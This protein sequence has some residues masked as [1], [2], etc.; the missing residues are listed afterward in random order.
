MGGFQACFILHKKSNTA[1][2]T[3]N[4]SLRKSSV[5]DNWSYI[6]CHCSFRS[7]FLPS[8]IKILITCFVKCLRFK[9]KMQQ[10]NSMSLFPQWLL[11]FWSWKVIACLGHDATI[12]VE[13]CWQF[14]IGK[15]KYNFTL[16]TV[17][18]EER[19]IFWEVKI[20][21]ILLVCTCVLFRTVSK[22]EVFH[23]IIHIKECKDALRQ[24]TLHVLTQVA[25]CT[26]V[27]RIFEM[28]YTR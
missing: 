20:L 2:A 16:Y 10:S 11:H 13:N 27:D 12:Q 1:S 4:S 7:R 5:R 3:S 23:A 8:T 26:D 25:K 24:A 22:T 9:E 18:Q 19:S 28:Y 21:V 6:F 15:S 17:S 14:L